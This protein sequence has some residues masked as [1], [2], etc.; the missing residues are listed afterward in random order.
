MFFYEDLVTLPVT[1]PEQVSAAVDDAAE[2]VERM[3]VDRQESDSHRRVTDEQFID[4][5]VA[6]MVALGIGDAAGDL[7]R[8]D[9]VRQKLGILTQLLPEG[10]ST[11]D[12][13]FT[14]L[15]ARALLDNRDHYT[16]KAVA[17]TWREKVIAR[18]GA[19]DRGG[20]PLYGALWNLSQG[21]DPPRSG[22]DNV[23]NI[24]DGAAMRAVPFG[25]AGC[26]DPEEAARLA[27]IDASVSHDADGLWA[28]QAVAASISRALFGDSPDQVVHIAMKFIPEDSWLSRRMRDM[29]SLLESGQDLI[30]TYA[31]LH[32][33]FWLPRHSASPEAIPQA[34]ALYLLSGGDFRKAFVLSANFGRDADTICAL[35]LALCAASS[36]TS[37]YPQA[38]TEQ[39]RH[40]SGV[41]L[42]FAQEEDLVALAQELAQ[43]ALTRKTTG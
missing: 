38:W 14:V 20:T 35:T 16:A 37:C 9:A 29:L 33:T 32:E 39:V 43:Y 34:Y 22:Q 31:A 11:D 4:R 40:P 25:I 17:D 30:T 2:G 12:T 42:P 8:S 18:G 36:G 26:G 13:E 10:K 1:L 3:N 23:L 24:D 21:I 5:S 41:C 27:A 6:A 7:G 19:L 28:S 15:S